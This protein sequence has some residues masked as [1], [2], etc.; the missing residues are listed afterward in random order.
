M[1]IETKEV[2][3]HA[4]PDKVWRNGRAYMAKELASD[5]TGMKISAGKDRCS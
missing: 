5:F 1:R 3:Y 2:L 4:N